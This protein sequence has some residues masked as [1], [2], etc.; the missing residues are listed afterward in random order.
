MDELSAHSA[1]HRPVFHRRDLLRVGS[2]GLA[3]AVASSNGGS[4][5][6]ESSG[7]TNSPSARSIVVLWMSGGV[8]HID[9]FDPKPEAPAEI[10]GTLGAIDTSVPGIRFNES[11]PIL[12]RCAERL[13]V[14]RTFAHDSNDH[15]IGQAHCLSGRPVTAQQTFSEPNVGAVCSSR[16]GA[17][18]GFPGYVAAPGTTRAGAETPFTAG[19]LGQEF[20]PFCTG[21]SRPLNLAEEEVNMQGLQFPPDMSAG[22]L[23]ARRG[24]RERLETSLRHLDRSGSADAISRQYGAA[25]DLMLSPAVRQAFDLR[26]ES[27]ATRDRY[28]RTKIGQR[29]LLAH[30]LVSA[31][32]PFVLV[33]YGVDADSGNTWDNHNAPGQ[34]HPPIC[35][36]VRKPYHLAGADQAFAALLEDLHRSGRLSE[37]LVVFLTEFGRTPKINKDGGRDHWCYAGSIFFA[38]GGAKGGQ[39]IGATD[40]QGAYPLGAG[41]GPGDAAATIYKAAGIDMDK[42]L[43]DRQG[44]PLPVVPHGAPIPGI[45]GA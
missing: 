18:H 20:D 28:G 1:H 25:F 4:A 7:R 40:A 39:V 26:E 38:G 13:A 37:T 21:G 19:W 11:L 41:Y 5:G 12:A 43:I 17:R 16:L 30:R 44:R 42:P 3:G 10:R 33:D 34:N 23:S 6:A 45:I 14:V 8:T 36:I 22:R 15:F 9:S 35:E 31:G 2:I 32:A 29:C 24:L 27:A